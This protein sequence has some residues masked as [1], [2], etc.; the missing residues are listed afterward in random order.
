MVQHWPF[1][2]LC[3]PPHPTP[4]RSHFQCPYSPPLPVRLRGRPPKY[5][6]PLDVDGVLVQRSLVVV[7]ADIM[8]LEDGTS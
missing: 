8:A 1:S 6:R 2:R 7:Y 3:I 4:R 5:D